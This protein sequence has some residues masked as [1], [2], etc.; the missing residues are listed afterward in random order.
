M[1]YFINFACISMSEGFLTTTSMA[2]LGF[3]S[4][5]I[6]WLGKIFGSEKKIY[7]TTTW[8]KFLSRPEFF[9]LN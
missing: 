5:Q 4:G 6:W 7:V 9:V 2:W 1:N 3:F 8:Y